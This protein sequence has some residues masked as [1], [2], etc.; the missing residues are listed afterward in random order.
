MMRTR[1][2]LATILGLTAGL[3]AGPALA[4][5]AGK[6]KTW[7]HGAITVTAHIR[8]P[9]EKDG[10]RVVVS[11]RGRTVASFHFTEFNRLGNVFIAE[12]DPANGYPEVIVEEYTGGAHCCTQIWVVRAP[13]K[14]SRGRWR[15]LDLGGFDGGD[16]KPRDLDGDGL[17]ELKLHDG[18]FLYLYSSYV[19]SYPPPKIL[20]VRHGK[21]VDLTR[22]A[23]MRPI[24]R[25]EEA[26]MR[27]WIAEAEKEKGE[28]NGFL[29]GYVALKLLLGEGVE[30][31]R[32]M[33]GKHR[34]TRID[35]CPLP[36]PGNTDGCPVPV[37]KL[38][39]PA[40]L[41][42]TLRELGYIKS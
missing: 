36:G 8:E 21:V 22:K 38:P 16:F 41:L 19:G 25:R 29:A 6:T 23:S 34:P 3:A 10:D 7:R 42:I 4:E 26:R 20:S 2:A 27:K 30:G 1:R 14:W 33:L 31:W 35:Y 9:A 40:H 15:A 32:L 17:A 24:L 12:M 13:A 39:Y 5:G 28:I 11:V 18:A 37:L